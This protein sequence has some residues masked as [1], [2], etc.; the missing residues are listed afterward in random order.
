MRTPAGPS[1]TTID[2]IPK[3]GIA[4]VVPEAPATLSFVEPIFVAS[5]FLLP[6]MLKPLPT[7]NLAFSSSVMAAI[8][9]LLAF[10][11]SC[12]RF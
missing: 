5:A 6:G 9:S 4:N 8:I 2:G 1:D 7:T 11:P 3:R 12:G 10:L